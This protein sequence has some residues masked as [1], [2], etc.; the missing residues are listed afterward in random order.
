M[1]GLDTN[2][3]VRYVM[4]DDP[5]QSRKATQLIESLTSD[6]PAF[7]PIVTIVELVWV[8]ESSYGLTRPQTAQAL[9]GLLD[10]RELRVDRAEIVSQALRTY[11]AGKADFADALIARLSHDAGCEATLTFDAVAV[12]DAG[13]RAIGQ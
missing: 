13:M 8:L 1:I 2:V 4:Q 5:R 6:D 9:S 11:R 10:S 3:V 12:R 7:L